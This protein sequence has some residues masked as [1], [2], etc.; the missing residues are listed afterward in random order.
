MAQ[1]DTGIRRL[2][3]IPA[4]YDYFQNLIGA[5]A[6]RQR[7]IREVLKPFPGA[8][9]LDIGCG[10]AEILKF[11][12]ENID[13]TGFDMSPKYIEAARK[14]HGGRGRFTCENVDGFGAA[15]GFDIAFSF[16]VLHHLG[17]E[18]ARSL[19]RNALRALKPGGRLVTID[20]AFVPGQSFLARLAVS[21][22]R[23]RN[24]RVPEAYAVL[25]RSAFPRIKVSIWRGTLKIPYDH[26]VLECGA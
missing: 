4:V 11:L 19:F 21:R 15:G 24:V 26:A 8:R 6:L 17:D 16:G 1:I 22:D 9:I 5:N 25:G 12:P 14:R 13:Y 2:L 10:T 3:A 20:P 23:G 7:W 18:E